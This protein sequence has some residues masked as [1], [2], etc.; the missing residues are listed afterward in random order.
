[1]KS[2][3][4]FV[5]YRV[6]IEFFSPPNSSP[7]QGQREAIHT[8]ISVDSTNTTCTYTLKPSHALLWGGIKK[9][10][11]TS[12]CLHCLESRIRNNGCLCLGKNSNMFGYE[13]WTEM[14]SEVLYKH[15]SEKFY[16]HTRMFSQEGDTTRAKHIVLAVIADWLDFSF[17]VES[18][19]MS[20]W[21]MPSLLIKHCV[22]QQ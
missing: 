15:C 13:Q 20:L 6:V 2:Q 5:T 12:C 17:H 3:W 11:A 19:F 9:N 16:T 4:I 10:K 7:S 1:M 21:V 14:E 18:Y 8:K 22:L